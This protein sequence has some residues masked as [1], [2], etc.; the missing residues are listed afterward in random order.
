MVENL[1]FSDKGF[2]ELLGLVL[3]QSNADFAVENGIYYVFEIQRTDVIKK[4]K[5]MVRLPLT[6]VAVQDLPNLLPAEMASQSLYRLDRSSNSVIL[7]GSQAQIAPLE[8]FIRKLDQPLGGKHYYR[9]DLSYL[10][11]A[12]LM[13]FLPSQL[14]GRKLIILPEPHS[15]VMLLSPANKQVM[16][17]LILTADHREEGFPVHLKYIHADHLLRYLPPSVAKEDIQLTGDSSVVFFTGTQTKREQFLREL[18]VL[19]RPVPQIR[20]ELLVIQYQGSENASW[21]I[22]LDSSTIPTG[23]ADYSFLG[24]IGRLLSLNFDIVSTFGILFAVKLNLDISTNTANVLADT[25]L[26]GLSGQGIRFQ[27]TTTYRYRDIEIDPDTGRAS[28]TGVTREIASG[29]IITMNGW[30]SG[31][32]MIT[33][34]VSATVSKRGADVS[35]ATGNPPPTSERIVSTHVRTPSGKP[36]V[37][38]GL[39]QQETTKVAQKVPFLG[40]IPIL[41]YLFRS[42]R[43]SVENTEMVIYIVPHVEY[44]EG[45][46]ADLG[47]R[48]E[49]LYTRHAGGQ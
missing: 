15:F 22:G 49:E 11:A 3:E 25:T 34:D 29:L 33:M 44:P 10:K 41:G 42:S 24:S 31:D 13:A 21:S 2:D 43:D 28:P 16:D 38:S 27:N 36:V 48:I 4:L 47:R 26:N 46:R 1:H 39:I 8:E 7:N 40:D 9:F 32:G 6:Y 5:T 14:V 17:D 23:P 45:R 19:D 12:E 37:I 30:V 35:T 18:A 20:Y